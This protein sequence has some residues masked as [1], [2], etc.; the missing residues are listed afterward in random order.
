MAFRSK[1]RCS[2]IATAL[3][4]HFPRFSC[5]IML[6]DPET[7]DAAGRRRAEPRPRASSRC[8]TARRSSATACSCG[9][10][11]VLREPVYVRD[12]ATDDR[13]IDH[14][15][16]AAGARPARVVVDPDRRER[17]RRGARHARRVR[18][19]AAPPRRGA[20][21]DLLPARAARVDRDRAQGVRGA[22]RAPV[23]A[24]PAH[25]AA[26][27]PAV[28]RPARPG[29]RALPAHEVERRRGVPRPRPLQ[30]HQRQ[31]RPRR[32]R[33]AA[34]RGGAQARG[35]DPARRHRC[36][37]RRRRVHDPVR[38][39]ARATSARELAV[40]IAERLLTTRHPPDGR[41]RHRD[42]R[43]RERRHRARDVGRRAPRGDCS[44]TPT[45]RCTTPRSRGAVASRCSTTR[46]AR[47]RSPRT[48]PRTRCT[49]RSSAASSASSSSRSSGCPTRGASAPRRLLR[50]QHP[51]RGLIGP[52]EFIPL[53]E[54]TGLIVQMGW[55]VIEEAA[56]HAA[57]WQLEQ[58]EP[59][60]V[61]GEP[62]GPP[63]RAA[64]SRRSRR[65]GDRADRASSRRA[66]ASRSPRAC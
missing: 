24:R 18:G 47:A 56:R 41:A 37:V 22:A 3:E 30:E 4:G 20:P 48:R 17:R 27:P 54:E 46:C 59:F 19:R 50:W 33:R 58:S 52:S 26:E 66:C 34:R 63:A 49:A 61:V 40:E 10:A 2:T 21:A 11:A 29:D 35:G 6:L 16:V 65:R 15:D 7:L 32:R 13:W 14:R 28:P 12:V 62:L 51:E 36:P 39:P 60:Q 25:R 38:G 64:R 57:R 44:A 8:S 1:R 53:A 31:P 42:V 23:D 45:P 9:A 5:A 55:W 43:R